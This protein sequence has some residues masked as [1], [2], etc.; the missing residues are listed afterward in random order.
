MMYSEGITELGWVK[1]LF[2]ATDLAKKISWKQ[3][4]KRGYYVLEAPK[5][6]L[7][8]PVSFKWFAEDRPKDTPEVSPMPADYKEYLHGM[9]TQSGKFEFSSS[10]LKRFAP[11]DPERGAIP[12]YIPAWEGIHTKELFEKYP[13]NLITPHPRFSFH[14]MG[15]AKDSTINDIKD[16]RVMIN[17][18]YYWIAR[19]NSGDAKARNIEMNDLVKLY[20]DRG[21]VICAAQVTDRVP[22]GTIHSYEASASYDPIG[23]PG[24]SPDRG[25]CVNLLTPHRHIIEKAHAGAMNTCL[26]E[27]KKWNEEDTANV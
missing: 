25:G 10:S 22:P 11:D 4:L 2:E 15:D 1:R 26:I 5:E 18:Y 21:A 13:L 16:H 6:G 19:I 23:E 7:R 17:G 14:S 24:S 20:N 3:F 12:R 27:I 8:D 9:Q